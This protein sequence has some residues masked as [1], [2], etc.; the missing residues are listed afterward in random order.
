[1]SKPQDRPFFTE[2][3][4]EAVVIARSGAKADPRVKQIIDSV[5]RHLHAVVRPHAD[6][7]P[8]FAKCPPADAR[9]NQGHS[10]DPHQSRRSTAIGTSVGCFGRFGL[11]YQLSK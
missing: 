10:Y 1:M 5:V 7:E 9:R 2:D 6:L 4:S 11:R 3:H 8:P